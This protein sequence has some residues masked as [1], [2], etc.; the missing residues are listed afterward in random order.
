MPKTSPIPW[1][2][3]SKNI[4]EMR[5]GLLSTLRNT[6]RNWL[7][8]S[9]LLKDHETVHR[10]RDEKRV[11]MIN[12]LKGQTISRRMFAKSSLF[13][14]SSLWFRRRLRAEPLNDSNLASRFINP[15]IGA[16]TSSLL[17]EGKTFPGAATP[18]GMVQLSPDT[19]TGGAKGPGHSY[20]GD[21]APGY[22][23]EQTTI[24]GFSFTHMS[25]VGWYGDFG[26]LQAMPTTGPMKLDSGRIDH[27]GEGWR[28]AYSHA[29]ER[30]EANYYA[31][32]LSTYG[33]RA[34]LTAAPRAGMLQFTFP[35]YRYGA[36]SI[37]S[38]ATHWRHFHTPICKSPGRSSNRRLDALSSSWWRLGQWRGQGQLHG[39][40]LHGVIKTARALWRLEDRCSR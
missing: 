2:V 40:L 4:K 19:I 24:E 5:G 8:H 6:F 33:M 34:E 17:G 22:S 32:T 15:L 25:G 9:K 16:S 35:K 29:N 13:W 28:S 30:A 23:Y 38:G 18:F 14:M 1:R 31:V 39:L 37:E 27:P 11:K 20:E 12:L 10:Y 7:I 36:Y 26:N 3:T 21:N